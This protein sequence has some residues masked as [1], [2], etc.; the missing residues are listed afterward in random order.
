MP[1]TGQETKDGAFDGGYAFADYCS[2]A[3]GGFDHFAANGDSVCA[4]GDA[5]DPLV[6]GTYVTHVIMP[7][8]ADNHALYHIVREED[9]NVDLGTQFEPRSRRRRAPATCTR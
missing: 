1:I 5:P 2:A 4:D 8:D 3:R 6:A 9:V 7:K